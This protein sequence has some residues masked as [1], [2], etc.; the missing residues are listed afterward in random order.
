MIDNTLLLQVFVVFSVPAAVAGVDFLIKGE[1]KVGIIT[2]F[3][4]V[5]QI[6]T[7]AD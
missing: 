2:M 1:R 5:H 6:K 4:P 7:T 3:M